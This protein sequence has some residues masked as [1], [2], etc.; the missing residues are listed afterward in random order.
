MQNTDTIM[1]TAAQDRIRQ[2]RQ[3]KGLDEDTFHIR[4]YLNE[5]NAYQRNS[6]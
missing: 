5:T 2:Y 1:L 3:W 4:D 6:T